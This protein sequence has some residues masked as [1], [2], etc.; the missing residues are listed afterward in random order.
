M[1]IHKK[2]EEA[3]TPE[4]YK[5]MYEQYGQMSFD[6]TYNLLMDAI[7]VLETKL[8]LHQDSSGLTNE[9]ISTLINAGREIFEIVQAHQAEELT[10][11]VEKRYHFLTSSKTTN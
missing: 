6:D 3:D 10:S 8:I 1:G 7:G 4:S 11:R 9:E 5:G 2:A